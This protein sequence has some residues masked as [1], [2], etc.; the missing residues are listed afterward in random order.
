VASKL[1]LNEAKER[2]GRFCAFRERSPNEVVE[3]IKSWGFNDQ[4]AEGLVESLIRLNYIDE[5]RFANAY[6]HDKFEFNSWGKQ[7]IRAGIYSHKLSSSVIDEALEGIDPEHY[8][9]RILTLATNKWERLTED[10]VVI[11]KKKTLNFLANKGY[12]P[13]LIWKVIEVLEKRH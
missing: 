10:D 12:E 1:S 13:N 11:K 8:Q 9:E 3:K 6:C 2:A 5:Q 7:K 4:E